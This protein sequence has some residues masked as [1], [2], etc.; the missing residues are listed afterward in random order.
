MMKH[1]FT[2]IAASAVLS[3]AGPNSGAT[4]SID[5]DPGTFGAG[6]VD[7]T[8]TSPDTGEQF[9]VLVV[10]NN[11]INFDTY[12]FRL[13]FDRTKL[14]YVFAS[15]DSGSIVNIL[16]TKGGST[17]G[18]DPKKITGSG[19]IDTLEL[20][21]TLTGSD[22]VQ[23]PE[24]FG[25]I[26][27]ARFKSL[28]LL[29]AQSCQIS[30]VSASFLD[31]YYQR[32]DLPLT[33]FASGTYSYVPLFTIST[34]ATPG[35]SISP[36]GPASVAY[37]TDTTFTI[38]P[39]ATYKIDSVYVDNANKGPITS[40]T[41]TNVT[42]DHSIS[43]YFSHIT[44]TLTTQTIGNGSVGLSPSGGTYVTGT[45]VQLQ[46]TADPGWTFAG[47]SGD[48]TN[49]ANPLTI[50]MKRNRSVTATF[51]Q[52]HYDLTLNIVGSGTVPKDPDQTS[53]TYGT[54]VQLTAT[55]ATGWHF[56]AWSG[57][58]ATAA[59]PL[60][61]TMKRNRSV[62]ANFALTTYT[63]TVTSGDN[64]TVVPSGD[65]VLQPNV[66]Q[67]VTASPFTG[68]HFLQWSLI[69]GTNVTIADPHAVTTM[70]TLTESNATVRA[71]FIK[72][73]SITVSGIG[74]NADVYLYGQSGWVGRKMLDG[75]GTIN[76]LAPGN[77]LLAVTESGKRTEYIPATVLENQTTAI[78]VTLRNPA[79]IVSDTLVKLSTVAG[80]IITGSPASPV[81][82]DFNRD[83]TLEL[84]VARADGTFRYFT[85]SGALWSPATGPKTG[86]GADLS[87]SGGTVCLR[88]VDWNGDNRVDL[89]AA[90]NSNHLKLFTNIS[91][92]G[93]L[94]F[95]NGTTLYTLGSGTLTGFD[96]ADL[97]ADAKPDLVLGLADGTVAT[98]LAAS[99]F[100]WLSPSWDAALGLTLSGGAALDAGSNAAPCMV[101]ATGDSGMD[102]LV[103][104]SG[105]FVIL[106]KNRND[107]SYQDRGAMN[108]SGKPLLGSAIST[109]YGPTGEF[110]SFVLSDAGGKLSSGQALLRGD[111]YVADLLNEVEVMDLQAFGD[112]WGKSEVDAGWKWKCNLDLSEDGGGKQTIE[113]LDLAIFGD[114][115]LA[116]K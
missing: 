19:N 71:D 9:D 6:L 115:W 64:G 109:A 99:G 93:G 57:D 27:M 50:T 97:N 3:W 94:V 102:L 30:V 26:A 25:L 44:Y 68:Y 33:S 65:V 47:W 62:T 7:A 60:F 72:D 82:V 55:P 95:D 21:Y 5:M 67:G 2:L 84:L 53:Y 46:A 111:F 12:T 40:W 74:A 114:S 43:A 73:G 35:G 116:K 77:Y 101:E 41:F 31:S 49:T 34:T 104:N 90:D 18:L 36:A 85:K 16:K 23:A 69:S 20:S 11:V 45:S 28:L 48:T 17:I 96:I 106:Y 80:Q 8:R 113:V 91:S 37:G 4:I 51:T 98:A 10:T 110:V 81:M 70:V 13:V 79:P 88:A 63:L 61:I 108:C 15:F 92:T 38:S 29:P 78:T 42:A 59:N 39:D 87:V 103:A 112:V 54:S 1:L 24:G 76:A 86:S 14:S 52:D 83:G 66:A 105:G 89:I 107:G 56:T 22:T 100:T 32:D 75:P 58:T